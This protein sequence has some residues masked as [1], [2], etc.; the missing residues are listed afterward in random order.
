M[1]RVSVCSFISCSEARLEVRER[2]LECLTDREIEDLVFDR[3]PHSDEQRCLAHL[4]WCGPCQERVEEEHEFAR[5]TQAAANILEQETF[6]A[7]NSPAAEE[8]WWQRLAEWLGSPFSTR[9]TVVAASACVLLALGIYVPLRDAGAGGA[10]VIVHSERGVATPAIVENST[11]GHVRL[12]IDVSDVAPSSSYNAA[13]VDA[14]GRVLEK[15][16]L[17]ATGG[18]VS[19]LVERDLAPARYWVRL[20]TPDGQLLREYALLVR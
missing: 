14:V 5:A 11:G 6:A 15:K 10:E 8:R 19:F 7:R 1:G 18:S 3:L 9:W 12:R 2:G 4:L 20:S 13:L 17:A 16:S